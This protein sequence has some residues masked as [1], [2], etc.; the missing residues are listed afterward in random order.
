V[1]PSLSDAARRVPPR[2]EPVKSGN[3]NVPMEQN[4]EVSCTFTDQ[5]QNSPRLV[6]GSDP[7]SHDPV[8]SSQ[9]VSIGSSR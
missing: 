8:S 3:R 9:A 4:S 2:P 6:L 5:T 7:T 1:R